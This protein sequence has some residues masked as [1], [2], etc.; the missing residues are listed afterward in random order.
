MTSSICPDLS[1]FTKEQALAERLRQIG[2]P[3]WVIRSAHKRAD[4]D[5]EDY[6]VVFRISDRGW[7]SDSVGACWNVVRFGTVSQSEWMSAPY[8]AMPGDAQLN[9]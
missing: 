3:E 8:V 5:D 1:D 6:A 4:A 2:M 9:D 7:G